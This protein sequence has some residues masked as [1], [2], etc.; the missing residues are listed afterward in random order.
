MVFNGQTRERRR[1][2][3]YMSATTEYMHAIAATIHEKV[4]I[5]V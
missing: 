3:V 1:F 2:V 4:R 5:A